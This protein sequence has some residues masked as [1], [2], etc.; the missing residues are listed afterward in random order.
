MSIVA[1][2]TE[3]S[4]QTEQL[5]TTG[6][7]A[8]RMGLRYAFVWCAVATG[9]VVLLEGMAQLCAHASDRTASV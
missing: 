7:A 3:G 6:A 5:W 9:L 8:T 1:H 4:I 2:A